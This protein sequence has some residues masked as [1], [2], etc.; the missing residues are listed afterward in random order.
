M[1]RIRKFF[2]EV[3]MGWAFRTHWG[4]YDRRGRAG[5]S[6][7]QERQISNRAKKSACI[8]SGNREKIIWKEAEPNR[9]SWDTNVRL[10]DC[11][12]RRN[13]TS[14]YLTPKDVSNRA[15]IKL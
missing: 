9:S 15:G 6:T 12:M 4:L 13:L 11:R 10:E 7:W 3:R 14:L 1:V 2:V 5:N 8:C